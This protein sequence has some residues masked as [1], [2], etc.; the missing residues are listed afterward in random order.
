MEPEDW[1]ESCEWK[2]CH[3]STRNS[4]GTRTSGGGMDRVVYSFQAVGTLLRASRGSIKAN[5]FICVTCRVDLVKLVLQASSNVVKR[6]NGFRLVADGVGSIG[7]WVTKCVRP[8]HEWTVEET[9]STLKR[10][11]VQR[12][13][14]GLLTSWTSYRYSLCSDLRG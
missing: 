8:L 10:V 3:V 6:T 12:I 14:Y 11:L 7:S 4:L 2:I 13:R 5:F 9:A 1:I